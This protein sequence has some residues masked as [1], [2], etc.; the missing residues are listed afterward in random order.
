MDLINWLLVIVP[1]S[2]R[3]VPAAGVA[4][5]ALVF[6]GLELADKVIP[7]LGG[8]ILSG[9]VKQALS[10][11]GALCL[12]VLS[13]SILIRMGELAMSP[14]GWFLVGATVLAGWGGSQ[15]VHGAL[16]AKREVTMPV[17]TV[18]AEEF[19]RQLAEVQRRGRRD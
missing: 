18:S 14:N 12:P 8:P 11:L 19:T 15:V 13:Y 4:V 9:R 1:Q 16:E 17:V 5:G 3:D 2:L 7:S 6:A 10:V